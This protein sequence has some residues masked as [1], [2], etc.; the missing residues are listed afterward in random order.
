MKSTADVAVIGGGFAGLSLALQIARRRSDLDVVVIDR[1]RRPAPERTWTVGESF[2]ELGS[3]YL[4]DV[5]GLRDHL[6]AEQL[7]KFGLRFFVGAQPDFAD[8]F[9]LGVLSPIIC[10]VEPQV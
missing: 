2:A 6:E 9:E 1:K 4:R 3:H 8:R 10:D 5:L 7:P